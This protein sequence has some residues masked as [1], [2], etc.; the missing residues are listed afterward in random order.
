MVSQAVSWGRFNFLDRQ[1]VLINEDGS[2]ED[3][4]PDLAAA[5]LS[6]IGN[7]PRFGPR[8]FEAR[9]VATLLREILAD[10]GVASME[11]MGATSL[12]ELL[13]GILS[14]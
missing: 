9:D 7:V 14:D 6:V 2:R 5:L 3:L 12:S 13:Q 1:S 11:D 4:K 10:I 8:G